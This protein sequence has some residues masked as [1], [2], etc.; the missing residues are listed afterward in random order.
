[1]SGLRVRYVFAGALFLAAGCGGRVQ[2]IWRIQD[3][4]LVPPGRP[5]PIA[6][7]TRIACPASEAIVVTRNRGRTVLRVN[8]D[9]LSRQPAG[10]LATW[11]RQ[12]EERGCLPPENW[13]AVSGA[14]ARGW[15]APARRPLFA[16]T[17]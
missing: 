1:M 2:A 9:V 13:A 16:A 4:R 15:A 17:S 5:G 14:A 3:Q 7:P 6:L 10:W 8:T 11:T 12:A